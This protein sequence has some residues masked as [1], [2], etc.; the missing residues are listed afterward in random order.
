MKTDALDERI[1]TVLGEDA[2]IS[3]RELGRALNVADV[4]IG[5]R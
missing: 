4:T 1:L 3:N 2:R 5:K